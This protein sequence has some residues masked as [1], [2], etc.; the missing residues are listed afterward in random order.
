MG[1]WRCS[2][3]W[4]LHLISEKITVRISDQAYWIHWSSS[5]DVSRPFWSCKGCMIKIQVTAFSTSGSCVKM[6]A[7]TRLPFHDFT[8][9]TTRNVLKF[10]FKLGLLQLLF[11]RM[12]LKCTTGYLSKYPGVNNFFFFFLD[13]SKNQFFFAQVKLAF[14][15]LWVFKGHSFIFKANFFNTL[16]E[17]EKVFKC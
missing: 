14:V 6:N 8:S 5:L 9:E 16:S 17:S 12:Q 4:C 10:P 11:Y 13:N 2:N 7:A 1:I 15:C 3:I